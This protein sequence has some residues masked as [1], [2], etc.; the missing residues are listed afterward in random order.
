MH[1]YHCKVGCLTQFVCSSNKQH[2]N[3]EQVFLLKVKMA[4]VSILSLDYLVLT[5]GSA[6]V[7]LLISFSHNSLISF[8]I[9]RSHNVLCAV[10]QYFAIKAYCI[11]LLF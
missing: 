2:G 10:L 5:Q 9:S 8:Y 3:N 1:I 7:L 4:K 6:L 11:D